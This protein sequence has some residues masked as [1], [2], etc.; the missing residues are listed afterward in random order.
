MRIL[1]LFVALTLFSSCNNRSSTQEALAVES[2]GLQESML[3]DSAEALH[4]S[5][6]A[7]AQAYCNGCHALP[8]PGL[9]DKS[10]WKKNV[11]PQMGLRLGRSTGNLNP[12]LGKSTEEIYELLQAGIF[13]QEPYITEENWQKLEEYYVRNAP[14]KLAMPETAAVKTD[15]KDFTVVVPALNK[16][17]SAVTTMVKFLP[18]S[19]EL[20][21]GDLRNWVFRLNPQ[22]QAV[23]SMVVDTPPVD[24]LKAGG[25]YRVLTI[26]AIVPT[27][28]GH[29]RLHQS[30]GAAAAKSVYMTP[31][32]EGLRRPV[33]VVEADLDQDKLPD[34][35]VCNYGYNLGSLVWYQNLGAGK[36][37]PHML[38]NLPGARKA[39]VKDLN[40]DGLP[41]VVAMFA[42]GT[43][44]VRVFYNQG[45][46]KFKEENLLQLPPVYGMS[47]FDL[48]DFNQ[49]SAVDIILTNGDNAD[50]S[51]VLKP[52]HGIRI[53][54]N[55][56]KNRFTEKY[57]YPM[58]G[59]TKALARDF[60]QDGDLDIAAI[61]HFPDFAGAP[62]NGFIY[63]QQTTAMSFKAATVAQAHLG[64][65]FTMDAGD[66]DQDGDEDLILGSFT[67]ALTPAPPALQ[68]QWV[69]E[70]P[71]IVVLQNNQ[72]HKQGR[73]ALLTSARE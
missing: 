66:Y 63:L 30:P 33:N 62:E 18:A 58:P 11:L 27:D 37:K 61:S 40:G 39:E 65:W 10:T 32:L 28:K 55:D 31:L 8:D 54:L 6:K 2:V 35:I 22:L 51:Q 64:R 17:K 59:A 3:P 43:E 5:G 73:E 69:K 47:Y 23:D 68:K 29:G 53:Y 70:G 41:D 50:Y 7:L 13:P 15:L 49:D 21:V 44:A 38:K 24:I 9:L 45:A 16:G 36:Y 52:Y 20:W 42:Q 67:N 46:G 1:P 4:L 48:A 72:L 56:G 12:L 71:S 26:G 60:D 14:D 34:M 57:F 25:G 19:N